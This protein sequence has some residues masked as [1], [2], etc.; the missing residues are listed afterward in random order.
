MKYLLV[1]GAGV[2]VGVILCI[3]ASCM[4]VAGESE[5]ELEEM[6]KRLEGW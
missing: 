2:V 1:F 3:V 4:I 5:R 6:E